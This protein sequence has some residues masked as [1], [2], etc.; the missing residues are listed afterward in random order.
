MSMYVS[1]MRNKPAFGCMTCDEAVESL[2]IKGAIKEKAKNFVQ[3]MAPIS[4]KQSF[5]NSKYKLNVKSHEYE[6]VEYQ[7]VHEDHETLAKK[8][9]QLIQ[10]FGDK[11]AADI[12]INY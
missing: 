4:G 12:N 11:I 6:L 8:C 10:N 9:L 3:Q 1:P 7:L 2:V 5:Q